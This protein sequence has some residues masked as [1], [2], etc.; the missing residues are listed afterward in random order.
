M[1]IILSQPQ[2][3]YETWWMAT[4][5]KNMYIL[6]STPKQRLNQNTEIQHVLLP[7]KVAGA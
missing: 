2:Q 3:N 5:S 7:H 6:Q 4:Q 1:K